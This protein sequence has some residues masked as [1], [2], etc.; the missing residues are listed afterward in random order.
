M[1]K[2]GLFFCFILAISYAQ[3]TVIDGLDVNELYDKF[4]IIAKGMAETT[5]YKCSNV[6][7]AKKPVILPVV[8]DIMKSLKNEQEL[9]GKIISGGIKLLMVE[10]L[11][12][13]CNL[14]KLIEVLPTITKADGIKKMGQNMIDN[15]S[16][17][18]TLFKDFTK[19]TTEDGKLMVVGKIVAKI[20]GVSFK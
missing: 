7:I 13:N 18:E 9:T 17:L 15:A 20:V 3:T 14:N 16:N 1:N 19:A 10:G 8:E 4:T 5:E 11:A 12:D 6:L 2:L